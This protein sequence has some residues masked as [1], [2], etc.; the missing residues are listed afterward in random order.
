[1]EGVGFDPGSRN[2][3]AFGHHTD[4]RRDP[5]PISLCPQKARETAEYR[6]SNPGIQVLPATRLDDFPRNHLVVAGQIKLHPPAGEPSEA[7]EATIEESDTL[8]E[9]MYVIVTPAA[10]RANTIDT[11]SEMPRRERNNGPLGA[12]LRHHAPG[13]H[14]PLVPG[15]SGRAQ[16]SHPPDAPQQGHLFH[17]G[18]FVSPRRV[19]RSAFDGARGG[20]QQATRNEKEQGSQEFHLGFLSVEE[21][22]SRTP[23][24]RPRPSTQPT[25]PRRFYS[26]DVQELLREGERAQKTAVSRLFPPTSGLLRDLRTPR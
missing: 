12:R 23:R 18:L 3:A 21:G 10:N 26:P 22:Q 16:R 11:A 4:S 5:D 2:P 13:G 25:D 9:L 8:Q 7:L 6:Q 24:G 20:D 15:H 14:R 19:P 17:S 1:M